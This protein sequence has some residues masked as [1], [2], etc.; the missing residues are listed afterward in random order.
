MTE[1]DEAWELALAQAKERARAEGRADIAGYLDLR[2]R[3]DLLRR[4][5]VD[6][7]VDE[8]VTLAGKANRAGAGIQIERRDPHRFSRRNATM[9][10]RQVK[11]RR[12][13]REL[14][15][16]C[17][18][19]RTP[20]DGIVR[21]GGLACAN[22]KHLGRARANVELLLTPLSKSKPHWLIVEDDDRRSVFA[23]E[24]LK[25]HFITLLRDD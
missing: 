25:S 24:T 15:I 14:T 13:V 23:E 7:L 10:G 12:G 16:E 1:L 3:N 8:F 20:R 11:L 5:A 4:T 21:G 22:I 2:R 17:G 18:W 9:V 6:W 19:P